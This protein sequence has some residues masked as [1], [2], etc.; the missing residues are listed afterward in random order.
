MAPSSE[1]WDA[2]FDEVNEAGGEDHVVFIP[3]SKDLAEKVEAEQGLDFNGTITLE[4]V[5]GPIW[6]MTLDESDDDA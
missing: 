2:I 1:F 4:Q 3:I 6:E 5:K